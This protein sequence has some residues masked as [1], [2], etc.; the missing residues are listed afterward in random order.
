MLGDHGL[1]LQTGTGWPVHRAP[2]LPLASLT[3]RNRQS[4]RAQL[5]APASDP[6]GS[7]I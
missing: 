6:S 7:S 2:T 1:A 4:P 5:A 3:T